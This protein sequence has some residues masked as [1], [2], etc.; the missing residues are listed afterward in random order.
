MNDK[1]EFDEFF[2]RIRAKM[3]ERTSQP[4]DEG[5]KKAIHGLFDA[6]KSMGRNELLDLERWLTTGES[7]RD[8]LPP[9]FFVD[10]TRPS[11]KRMVAVIVV[12]LLFSGLIGWFYPESMPPKSTWQWCVFVPM[13]LA[14][15]VSLWFFIGMQ[16]SFERRR[17]WYWKRR[18]YIAALVMCFCVEVARVAELVWPISKED[19]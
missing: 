19:R 14:T 16:D 13:F 9:L 18:K 17:Q 10:M 3:E 15:G 1:S 7:E 8:S 12:S 5:T 2:E 6:C 11:H 4:L